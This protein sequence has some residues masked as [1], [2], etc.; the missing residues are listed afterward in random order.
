MSHGNL[1]NG[2]NGTNG[3]TTP[4]P[5]TLELRPLVAPANDT[6]AC[7]VKRPGLL[8][9][10]RTY[11]MLWAGLLLNRLGGTI[12]F[13]LGVYLTRERGF[14]PETAGLVI[15]LYAVGGLVAGPVGG[16]LADRSGRRATLL[17]CTAA[18]GALMLALGFARG[19]LAIV[20]LAPL[21]GFAT[22][23]CR[24]PLQAAV[25]DVV[26]S[27]DRPRAYGLLY[28]AMNLG[29]AVASAIG[30]ALAER[31]FTLLF[32]IDALTTLAYGAIVYLGVPETR[33]AGAAAAPSGRGV[34]ALFEPFRDGG[35]V[36]FVLVQVLLLVAFAQVI[37]AL[38]LDMR[39]HGIGLGQLGWLLGLN[40]LYIVIAQPIALRLVRGV[41][42]V[43]WLAAGC[44]LTGLGLGATAFAHGALSYALTALVWTI[45]EVGFSTATP[46]I[47]ADFA[48]AARRGAYQG[49]Y[50]LAWGTA[51]VLAPTLG[52]LTLGRLGSGAL[53][54]ACLFACL[55]AAALHLRVTARRVP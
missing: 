50:Q 22:D 28:W 37:V 46:A 17:A 13:L 30:G 54:G 24:P 1:P 6:V 27:G 35:F 18:A 7:S 16:A 42:H 48:P 10:P 49:T 38:P 19:T 40:G 29:F 23:G 52:T 4:L 41:R 20:I 36:R 2:T 45:G 9:L 21:L 15:S 33:P 47:V 25:A 3:T 34:T 5:A 31:H 26:A 44:V 43:H 39:A 11:W 12:F 51:S 8:G 14:A 55:L 53:W 32:V